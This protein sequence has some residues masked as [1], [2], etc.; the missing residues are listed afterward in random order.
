LY[1]CEAWSLTLKEGHGLRVFENR[2]VRRVF[3]P[4]WEKVAGIWRRLH[5]DEL[6][7]LFA[8]L[9]IIR[10]I[11]SSRMITFGHITHMTEMRNVYKICWKT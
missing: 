2:L 11:N 8:T 6:H 10:V 3:G 7:N 5:N 1:G 4:M 9:N